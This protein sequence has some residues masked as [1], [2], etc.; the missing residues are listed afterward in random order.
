[1]TPLPALAPQAGARRARRRRRARCSSAPAAR[2]GGGRDPARDARACRLP[3][4]PRRPRRRAVRA[5][6]A[7]HDGHRR[8]DDGRRA[9]P[10]TRATTRITRIGALAAP[11]VDRRAA[12][13]DQRA[14]RARCRW[15]ARARPCRCR[16]TATPTASAAGW[17]R[18]PGITGWAQVN[19]RASLPWHERIELD[20]WY[21]EHAS[22][23]LD[24]RILARTAAH[25][26]HGPRALP[27]RDGRLA[28][29]A[30][31]VL[32]NV[33]GALV[34]VAASGTSGARRRPCRSSAGRSA[35]GPMPS[36]RPATAC[37]VV[38]WNS[39]MW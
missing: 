5:V 8:R 26:R 25:G 37:S 4:A 22:L 6:Q 34:D 18:C 13:P 3:P 35:S 16:S 14:A 33:L 1:M 24:L 31:D 15:S 21:V 10:S 23:R 28:R 38:F 19:G 20:L 17:P 2:P 11:H 36:R 12:E 32:G 27:R 29:A 30:R 9:S 7:A 39:S